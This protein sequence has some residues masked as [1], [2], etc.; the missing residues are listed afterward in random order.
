MMHFIFYIYWGVFM[1]TVLR[2]LPQV[3]LTSSRSLQIHRL[4]S[5]SWW[6]QAACGCL[7]ELFVR[8]RQSSDEVNWRPGPACC[9]VSA[10]M[11]SSPPQLCK[12]NIWL[13]MCYCQMVRLKWIKLI[14][15]SM[16]KKNMPTRINFS[17]NLRLNITMQIMTHY[18][19]EYCK[20]YCC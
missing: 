2:E 9:P 6:I 7:C 4:G 10:G 13:W 20:S 16:L 15:I 18:Q 14:K 19:V 17:E 8:V 12:K 5:V 1:F 3:A 11:G